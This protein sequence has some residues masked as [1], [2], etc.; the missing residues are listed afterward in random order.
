MFITKLQF[1]LRKITQKKFELKKTEQVKIYNKKL[2][3][4]VS[5]KTKGWNLENGEVQSLLQKLKKVKNKT[6]KA[7]KKCF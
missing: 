3:F 2:I 5:K 1:S 7:D 6:T 4:L